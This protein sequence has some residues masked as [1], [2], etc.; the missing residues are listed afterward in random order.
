LDIWSSAAIVIFFYYVFDF[1]E[2]LSEEI[3]FRQ[4]ILL[5]YSLNFLFS[6][7]VLMNLPNKHELQFE[8]INIPLDTFFSLT[9]PSVLALHAG[10]YMLKIRIFKPQFKAVELELFVNERML[11]IFVIVGIVFGLNSNSEAGALGY[12]ATLIGLLRY[13]GVF[14]LFVID[15]RKSIP[16]LVIVFLF[17]AS[18]ALSIGMFGEFVQWSAFFGM[19]FLY[20]NKVNNAVKYTIISVGFV[21]IFLLQAIKADYRNKVWNG[22]EEAGVETIIST[23]QNNE[24]D[25]T[26]NSTIATTLER[27]NQA[28]ILG[29]V[30]DRAD[31]TQD[32][33]QF[34]L[35]N[36]YIESALLPRFL[37]PDKLNSSDKELFTRFTGHRLIGSTSM[38]MGVL[39][40]GYI[41]YGYWGTIVASLI[42]GLFMGIVCKII[43]RWIKVSPF[44]LFF[45]FPVLFYAI[46][47]DCDTQTLLGNLFK[48]LVLYSIIVTITKYNIKRITLVRRVQKQI[49][50][51]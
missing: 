44:F 27:F 51:A 20:I 31:Y 8:K 40:D 38:G 21:L 6:P 28:W 33:Q 43:E 16:Y 32:F 39:A 26:S 14:G 5:I 9:I 45:L 36:L 25:I 41:A 18:R 11:K 15:K 7:A 47:P 13:V 10:L 35:I 19:L 23:S 29:K 34:T 48:S 2:S 22:Q 4:F 42:L 24:K 1:I 37:A 50:T 46:R 3:P 30:I 49:I 17:S 12:I